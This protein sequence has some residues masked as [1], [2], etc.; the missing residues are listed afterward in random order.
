ML[1]FAGRMASASSLRSLPAATH[2][3]VFPHFPTSAYSCWP[4]FRVFWSLSKRGEPGTSCLL[5][6]S[7]IVPILCCLDC[8]LCLGDSRVFP[9]K[10]LRV[11]MSLVPLPLFLSSWQGHMSQAMEFCWSRRDGCWDFLNFR[12]ALTLAKGSSDMNPKGHHSA[13]SSS[14]SHACVAD[15]KD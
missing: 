4:H 3:S 13:P 15:D 2:S 11:T 9:R 1:D 7:V 8:D 6:P 10:S 5:V 12:T 14:L